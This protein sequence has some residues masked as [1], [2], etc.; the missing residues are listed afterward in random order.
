M[1]SARKIGCAFTLLLILC[2]TVQAGPLRDR[3]MERM[4]N[5]QDTS[6]N[7]SEANDEAGSE[8]SDMG[9]GNAQSCADWSKKVKRL[10]R[11]LGDKAAGPP[12]DQANIAYGP[13]ALEKL[14]VFYAK[15]NTQNSAQSAPMIVMVHGGGWCVGDKSM[16]GVVANKVARW[17]PKGFVFVSVNYPM[18]AEGAN[19]LAQADYIAKAVAYIQSHA[20]QWGGDGKKVILMGHSAGAHLISLVNADARIR[21]ANRMQPVLGAISL[22]AGAIDVVKQMPNV[23]SFLKVRYQEAFGNT[24]AEWIAASPYH[25]LRAGAAPWLGVCSTQRKDKPCDQAQAYAEKS[26]AMGIAAQTLPQAKGHGG[27]NKDLGLEN[28]YTRQVERFMA[29][30]NAEVARL[31][32]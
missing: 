7:S 22:D 4:Q 29:G 26:T 2:S 31:L 21:D 14:D 23:Y 19:A 3:F 28:D 27:L 8:L 24:E 32:Q 6:A 20:A 1:Q 30:L 18:V 11:L 17:T 15:T 25:Q 12:P 16:S 10:G 13:S 9:G 5:R